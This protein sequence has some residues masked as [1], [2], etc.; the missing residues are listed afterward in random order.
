[1]LAMP[2]DVLSELKES[3]AEPW[4]AARMIPLMLIILVG[5]LAW[6]ITPPDGLGVSAYRTAIV[7]IEST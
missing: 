7:F 5:A 1:M 6:G 4:F 2:T 3:G